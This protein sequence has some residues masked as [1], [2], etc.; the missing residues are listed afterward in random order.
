MEDICNKIEN[1]RYLTNTQG[2]S[3][4][5]IQNTMITLLGESG[6]CHMGG[7]CSEI[8]DYVKKEP[9]ISQLDYVYQGMPH[10]NTLILLE[11]PSPTPASYIPSYN[12]HMFASTKGIDTIFADNRP[13][14]LHIQNKNFYIDIAKKKIE[15]LQFEEWNNIYEQA[16]GF[17]DFIIAKSPESQQLVTYVK[18]YKKKLNSLKKKIKKRLVGDNELT[19]HPWNSQWGAYTIYSKFIDDFIE[20]QVAI[21]DINIIYLIKGYLNKTHIVFVGG[22]KHRENLVEYFNNNFENSVKFN[23]EGTENVVNIKGSCLL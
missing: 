4:V 5:K 3:Q 22:D 2:F 6:T 11:V 12:L 9:H 15:H 8:P 23:V 1:N 7:K 13:I 17:F 16:I 14:V 21:L 10:E 18:T 19:A 20:I